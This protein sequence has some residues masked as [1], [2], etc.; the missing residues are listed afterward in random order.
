M[1]D[2]GHVSDGLYLSFD[3]DRYWLSKD[4]VVLGY[5]GD[6]AFFDFDGKQYTLVS[7]HLEER[8]TPVSENA[9]PLLNTM[10]EAHRREKRRLDTLAK[11]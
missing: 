6:G 7:N 11:K 9:W 10:I 1:E 8:V 4:Q 2:L 5:V 3:G